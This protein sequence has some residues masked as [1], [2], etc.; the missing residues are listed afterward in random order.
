M[1]WLGA[2]VVL[3]H[4]WAAW[5]RASPCSLA[6]WPRSTCRAGGEQ[7]DVGG[8][9]ILG[10]E[11]FVDQGVDEVFVLRYMHVCMYDP[12]C[13]DDDSLL[14]GC[15]IGNSDCRLIIIMDLNKAILKINAC[16]IRKPL[17]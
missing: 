9:Q 16:F 11:E 3:A 13:A 7:V 6:S 17:Y 2:K 5:V 4:C 12:Y 10:K 1:G 8:V 14:L 15:C